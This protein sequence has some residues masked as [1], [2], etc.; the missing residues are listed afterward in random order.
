MQQL[1]FNSLPSRFTS[2]LIVLTPFEVFANKRVSVVFLIDR[3][4]CYVV[5]AAEND[6]IIFFPIHDGA[7]F[8]FC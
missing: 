2:G 1:D 4:T 7:I 5:F 8:S 6:A 3:W